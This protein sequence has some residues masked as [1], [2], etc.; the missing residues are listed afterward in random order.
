MRTFLIELSCFYVYRKSI[1]PAAISGSMQLLEGVKLFTG[2]HI[3][4]HPHLFYVYNKS[5]T[6]AAAMSGCG[7]LMAGLKLCA[8]CPITNRLLYEHFILCL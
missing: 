3:T 8:G 7:Q 1:L 4:N 5:M 6:S 2:S